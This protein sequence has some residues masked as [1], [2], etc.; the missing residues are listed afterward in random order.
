M[1][2]IFG[3]FLTTNASA[4]RRIGTNS[5]EF[6]KFLMKNWQRSYGNSVQGITNEPSNDI[7]M[8][9]GVYGTGIADGFLQSGILKF[10]PT[11]WAQL[12]TTEV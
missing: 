8:Q 4:R 9:K 12:N 3:P 7:D 6:H 5:C 2:Q 10:N 1:Y 11:Y